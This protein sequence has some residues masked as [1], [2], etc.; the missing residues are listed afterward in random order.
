MKDA[1]EDSFPQVRVFH[2]FIFYVR[3]IF[4][5]SV[6][7]V[8]SV[9]HHPPAAFNVCCEKVTNHGTHGQHGEKSALY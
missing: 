8:C 9:V 1:K 4:S 2:V 7:S 5:V 6:Y 3:K